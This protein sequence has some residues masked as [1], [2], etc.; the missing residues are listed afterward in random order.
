MAKRTNEQTLLRVERQVVKKQDPYFDT[1]YSI[2]S[3]PNHTRRSGQ[4]V[5]RLARH[6]CVLEGDTLRF[7]DYFK[8]FTIQVGF[9]ALP[10][11]VGFNSLCMLPC[12][13]SV[14]IELMYCIAKPSRLPD[15]GRYLQVGIGTNDLATVFSN[16]QLPPF[17]INGRELN[18]VN[19]QYNRKFNHYQGI[20]KK[21]NHR[22]HSARLE[23]MT[24]KR[25]GVIEDYMHKTS[26]YI[27][28]CCLDNS[29]NTIIIGNNVECGQVTDY[30]RNDNENVN[31]QFEPIPKARLI[32]MLQYK[33]DQEG[34]SVIMADGAG[35]NVDINKFTKSFDRV[36][37]G[38]GLHPVVIDVA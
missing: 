17:I 29:I 9:T 6:D 7:P 11:F 38:A 24:M 10:D 25:N 3:A 4:A 5:F 14:V 23:R 37:V 30:N 15:N 33:A 13:R 12:K 28:N 36:T 19:A 27:V 35:D 32:E 34:I 20:C 2:C 18:E 1:L 31:L 8:G 21:F 26:R 16:T 22:D